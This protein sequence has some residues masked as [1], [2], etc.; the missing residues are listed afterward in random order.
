MQKL[1]FLLTKV[2]KRLKSE[3]CKPFDWLISWWIFYSN[4]VQFSTFT[5]RGWPKINVSRDGKLV[6]GRRFRSNNREMANPIGRFH[7]CSLVVSGKGELMIGNNVGMSSTAIVCQN[8]I[9]IG[10]NVNLGGGTVIYDTDFHSLDPAHR[11]DPKQDGAN[12]RTE[13]VII[14][15][16]VFIGG[17]STILKGVTIGEGAVIGACSV[18]T[19]DVPAYE[20][21]GGN[22]AKRIR[23]VIVRGDLDI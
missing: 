5:N 23:N 9:V 19:R 4:N 11:R 22:P 17:H 14:G 2:F 7:A 8:K 10:N 6:I 21:W 20:V 1:A 16:D 12:T 15:N 3:C 13:P 18:V